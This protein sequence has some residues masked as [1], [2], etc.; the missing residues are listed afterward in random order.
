MIFTGNGAFSVPS[1]AKA[2]DDFLLSLGPIG[3]NFGE[4]WI[5]HFFQEN[6]FDSIICTH[7]AQT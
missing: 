2:N 6:A 1:I 7:F 5:K 3:T 4:I